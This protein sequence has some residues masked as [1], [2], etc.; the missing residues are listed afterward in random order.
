VFCYASLGSIIA[1]LWYVTE[2]MVFML[3]VI[4]QQIWIWSCYRP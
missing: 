4:Y 2:D 3:K 1:H